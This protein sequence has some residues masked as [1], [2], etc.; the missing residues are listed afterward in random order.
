MFFDGPAESPPDSEALSIGPAGDSPSPSEPP[1]RSLNALDAIPITTN[2]EWIEVDASPRGKSKL[3]FWRIQTLA[4]A[5]VHGLGD[6]PVL[7]I[8]C[9]LNRSNRMGEEMKAIR[10]RS[11]RFDPAIVEPGA[12]TPLAALTAW[13]NRVQASS[14]ANCLPSR[15]FLEGGF[16]RFDSLEDYEREVLGAVRRSE[17]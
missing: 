15:E 12:P 17:S 7:V 5:A 11:D 4:M 6:R 14:N 10:F 13:V 2:D 1:L 16:A 3:P 8:D 9:V